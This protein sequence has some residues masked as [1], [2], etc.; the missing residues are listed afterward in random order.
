MGLNNPIHRTHPQERPPLACQSAAL[1][2]SLPIDSKEIPRTRDIKSTIYE[3]RASHFQG[4][5]DNPLTHFTNIS[6]SDSTITR[7]I[8]KS[9]TI[10]IAILR[11]QASTIKTE[12]TFICPQ[13]WFEL[14]D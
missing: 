13:N 4:L 10:P 3:T 11:A 7:E 14:S 9:N 2:A 5:E 12:E 1:F 8:F 6:H